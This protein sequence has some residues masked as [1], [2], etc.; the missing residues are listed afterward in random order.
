MPY[1]TNVNGSSPTMSP[2]IQGRPKVFCQHQSVVADR[3]GSTLDLG[4]QHGD[5]LKERALV[6]RLESQRRI[7]R[8][9]VRCCLRWPGSPVSRPSNPS[10]ARMLKCTLSCFS[11]MVTEFT[12][13]GSV[14]SR[15][16]QP[17]VTNA[18]MATMAQAIFPTRRRV[19]HLRI[20]RE[21]ASTMAAL[22]PQRQNAQE[23]TE[24]W[25]CCVDVQ[26]QPL[27]ES[28]QCTPERHCAC[29][30]SWPHRWQSRR[31]RCPTQRVPLPHLLPQHGHGLGNRRC[32]RSLCLGSTSGVLG[33]RGVVR[34]GPS[35][36]VLHGRIQC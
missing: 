16:A 13:P 30:L 11:S 29:W 1:P 23:C 4:V 19:V 15:W 10:L 14:K 7:V 28:R 31:S 2:P 5:L 32:R 21:K 36:Q 34:C 27:L 26:G 22:F 35:I 17:D 25:R 12:K 24:H 20:R 6:A 8:L 9:E 33:F 18:N 3:Q